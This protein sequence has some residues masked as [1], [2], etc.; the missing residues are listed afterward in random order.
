[1]SLWFKLREIWKQYFSQKSAAPKKI[2]FLKDA[3][4]FLLSIF[5]TVK[6]KIFKWA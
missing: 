2:D 5:K 4:F 6:N 3:I 1:M